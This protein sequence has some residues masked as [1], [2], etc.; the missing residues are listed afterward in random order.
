MTQFERLPTK[1][2]LLSLH[3]FPHI[4][5]DRIF[6]N[7]ARTTQF[8][9]LDRVETLVERSG[10]RQ[11]KV[12]VCDYDVTLTEL[13][14]SLSLDMAQALIRLMVEHRREVVILTSKWLKDIETDL[15][16]GYKG[17]GIN[18][19]SMLPE[20]QSVTVICRFF[21]QDI[22]KTGAV[23]YRYTA[24]EARLEIDGLENIFEAI[25]NKHQQLDRPAGAIFAKDEALRCYLKGKQL[26]VQDVIYFGDSFRVGGSDFPILDVDGITAIQVKDSNETLRMINLLKVARLYEDISGCQR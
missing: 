17:Q 13:H 18:F 20:D 9:T 3:P 11:A 1:A 7:F 8:V 23:A 12:F 14:Q 21:D 22:K 24:R 25:M 26:S 15:K 2:T 6:G 10:L 19:L 4:I 16:G 5:L